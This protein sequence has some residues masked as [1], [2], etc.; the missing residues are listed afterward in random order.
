MFEISEYAVKGAEKL[1]LAA[2][3][4]C[5]SYEWNMKTFYIG[6]WWVNSPFYRFRRWERG[7]LQKIPPPSWQHPLN[8]RITASPLEILIPVISHSLSF[9]LHTSTWGAGTPK[10]GLE[11]C[12]RNMQKVNKNWIVKL[13]KLCKFLQNSKDEQSVLSVERWA[14]SNS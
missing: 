13:E 10:T 3:E 1:H 5:K 9:I 11:V 2:R 7:G 6:R 4:S 12:T 8:A 14:T